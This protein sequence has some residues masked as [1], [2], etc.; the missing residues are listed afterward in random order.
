MHCSLKVKSVTYSY[1]RFNG[2]LLSSS[3]K[4]LVFEKKTASCFCR[5]KVIMQEG[6][7]KNRTLL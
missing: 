7:P 1:C 5:I 2:V 6:S 4:V 3:H